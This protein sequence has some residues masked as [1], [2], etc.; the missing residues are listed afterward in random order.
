MTSW[1]SSQHWGAWLKEHAILVAGTLPR[2]T[3]HWQEAVIC[4]LR[5]ALARL[6]AEALNEEPLTV[7][8][9]RSG[10]PLLQAGYV[11]H[12]IWTL[13]QMDTHSQA[14]TTV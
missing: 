6:T 13:R 11:L 1:E 3:A 8:S 7:T 9:P 12:D 2:L 10:G 14:W 5:L 4:R